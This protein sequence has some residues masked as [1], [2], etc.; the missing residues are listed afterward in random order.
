MS[1]VRRFRSTTRPSRKRADG[2]R[3]FRLGITCGYWPCIHAPFVQ[4]YLGFFVLDLWHG[5]PSYDPDSKSNLPL[6]G[7][8]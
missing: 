3:S 7:G 1:A 5:L 4:L 8:P 2:V 6:D